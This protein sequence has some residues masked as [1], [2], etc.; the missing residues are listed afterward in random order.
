LALALAV[1]F[2]LLPPSVM[3]A[4]ADT[5][6]VALVF[7]SVLAARYPLLHSL[8]I[9][10]LSVAQAGIFQSALD[11]AGSIWLALAVYCVASAAANFVRYRDARRVMALGAALSLAQLLD[12]MGALLAVFL[13][14]VCV[15]LPRAGE[16]ANKAGLLALL[17]FMPVVTAIVLA[18]A[19]GVLG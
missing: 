13:L 12:P 19:R 9:A 7:H 16:A 17:L 4:G 11:R 18:Y 14:P 10:A 6:F 8:A 2:P 5:L 1:L 3:L 15:G